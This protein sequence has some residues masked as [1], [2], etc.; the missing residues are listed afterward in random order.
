MEARINE[1]RGTGASPG[2]PADPAPKRQNGR[3]HDERAARLLVGALYAGM[4][5]LM[6]LL[7]AIHFR[8][9]RVRHRRRFPAD[10]PVL[11]IANHPATWTDVVVLDVALGRKLHFLAHQR[12]FRPTLRA[13]LLRLFGSLPVVPTR[14]D[15]GREARNAA[16]YRRCA[17]L[18]ARGEAIAVF[19][20]GTS[21]GDRSLQPLRAGAARIALDRI[22]SGG[23]LTVV[24][25][26][27]HYADRT[28]VRSD[29]MVSVGEPLVLSPQDAPAPQ[30]RATWIAMLTACFR[31]VLAALIVEHPDPPSPV[32]TPALVAFAVLGAPLGVAGIVLHLPAVLATE[33]VVRRV[34]DPTR[35]TLARMVVGMATFVGWYA[36]MAM[37]VLDPLEP[38][39]MGPVFGAAGAALGAFALT[40]TDAVRALP[41]RFGPTRF[42]R[43]AH[44]ARSW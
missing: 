10:G 9:L 11:L 12:L 37:V 42:A 15:P 33:L 7:V 44:G 31:D 25:V 30:G 16:T 5:W 34:A 1:L 8:R 17:E 27:I 24:P 36:W 29:V 23:C 40:W 13:W 41:G 28:R 26:G 20:E 39:W 4:P 6:R 32:S 22:G 18:L 21:V 43:P 38:W 3:W 35:V 2:A 19:P 14:D